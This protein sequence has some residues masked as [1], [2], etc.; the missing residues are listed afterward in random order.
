MITLFDQAPVF[1]HDHAIHAFDGGQAM[2]DDEAGPAFA[3]HPECLLDMAFRF[4]IE[5]GRCFVQDQDRR[6]LQQRARDGE[7]LALAARQTQAV[8]ADLGI[9]TARQRRYEFRD[10]GGLSG[11]QHML[12][13][14]V[15]QGAVGDVVVNAVIEQ[16]H[17]LTDIGYLFAQ[18]AQG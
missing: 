11:R 6:V 2:G 14:Q 13:R 8:V 3:Q 15:T 5:R 18:G 9:E 1:N 16:H 12:A 4:C 10:E 7:P 17:V